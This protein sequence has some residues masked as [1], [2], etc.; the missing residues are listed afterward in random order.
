M[1]TCQEL[2]SIPGV[3][4]GGGRDTNRPFRA[5]AAQVQPRDAEVTAGG[6]PSCVAGDTGAI[7][8]N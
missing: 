1:Q 3:G 4:G 6:R 7:M 2:S 8:P 5:P